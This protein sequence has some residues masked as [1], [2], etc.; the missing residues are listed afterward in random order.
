MTKKIIAGVVG[1]V[2]LGVFLFGTRF[3]GYVGTVVDSAKEAAD[4]AVPFEM[5]LKEAKKKVASLDGVLK[6]HMQLMAQTKTEIQTLGKQIADAEK[7]LDVQLAELGK[8]RDLEKNADTEFVSVN[9]TSGTKKYTKKQL[10]N[11]VTIRI[12][13]YKRGE[14]GLDL[15]RQSLE[16]NQTKYAE[17]QERYNQLITLKDQME[18]RI[19]ELESKKA[20]LDTRKAAEATQY[21]DSDVKEAQEILN[22]L[23]KSLDTQSNL[24]DLETSTGTGRIELDLSG[25]EE[26]SREELDQILKKNDVK[27]AH[28]LISTET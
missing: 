1:A 28:E 20:A 18:L 23:D 2:L 12:G 16:Q 26:T 5:K 7:N 10:E 27:P 8:L 24:L 15:K 14:E 25:E 22:E 17:F 3:F 6:E 9:T 4:A 11:E 19:K 13:Q 21:D